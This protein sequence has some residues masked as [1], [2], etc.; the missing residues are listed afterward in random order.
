MTL[1]W[2]PVPIVGWQARPPTAEECELVGREARYSAADPSEPQAWGDY[3]I[4]TARV[5][6]AQKCLARAL[7]L[8]GMYEATHVIPAGVYLEEFGG[9]SPGRLGTG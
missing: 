6:E 1:G 8:F 9:P 2:S 3:V 4:E 7:E 5:P